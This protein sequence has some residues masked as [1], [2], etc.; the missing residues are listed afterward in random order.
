MI[1]I[2][3]TIIVRDFIFEEKFGWI[4]RLWIRNVLRADSMPEYH[5][6][7]NLTPG[8]NAFACKALFRYP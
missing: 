7:A 8:I 6:C 5:Q 4:G 2:K 1:A 3:I